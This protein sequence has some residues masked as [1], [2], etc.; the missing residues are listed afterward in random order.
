MGKKTAPDNQRRDKGEGSIWYNKDKK[1]W[2]AQL[3]LGLDES[4]HKK[5]KTVSALSK[6]DVILKMREAIRS[7]GLI[8][9][10]LDIQQQPK[11]IEQK[12][13]ILMK[14]YIKNYLN[15][16]K[17]PVV[18]PKTFEWCINMSKHIIDGLGDDDITDI[19]SLQIQRFLNNLALTKSKSEK[20][21]SQ[22]SIKGVVMILKQTFEFAVIQKDI[23]E[24]PFNKTVVTPKPKAKLSEIPKAIPTETLREIF[25]TIEPSTTFKPIIYTLFYTGMRIGELLALRWEDLDEENG[26]IHIKRSLVKESMI[27]EDLKTTDRILTVTKTKTNASVRI[28]PVDP[29]LF[30]IL[31]ELKE[32]ILN[33]KAL[34]RKI[35]MNQTSAYIFINNKGE[36]RSYDGLRRQFARFLD[37][38]GI[39]DGSITFHRFRHTYA[40]ILIESGIN[41]RIV[42]ELLGHK[43]VQT[44]LS[45][46]TS[47][48]VEAMTEATKGFGKIASDM[49]D[50]K[51]QTNENSK[52]KT[53]IL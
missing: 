20:A 32:T 2:Y 36:L 30:E 34:Q 28:I 48:S 14:D 27:N 39:T 52:N 6:S 37:E 8:P 3:S 5:R 25:E 23:E 42:Q 33:N 49:I 10:R 26:L 47:V 31:N 44:T 15:F 53:Y 11:I 24:N 12:N 43:D 17:R 7:E 1:R 50:Y 19:T 41:P 46:Y 13:K 45:I 29:R 4:G 22:K 51:K 38:K 18:T 35:K 16:Y 9:E 21:L 40:T